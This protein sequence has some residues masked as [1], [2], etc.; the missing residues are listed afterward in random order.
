VVLREGTR[1]GEL[2]DPHPELTTQFI[3]SFV[4]GAVL[5]PPEGMTREAL[6]CHILRL[7]RS[8]IGRAGSTVTGGGA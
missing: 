4:R 5:Y 3:L 6:T 7:L 8:G 2:D 1:S